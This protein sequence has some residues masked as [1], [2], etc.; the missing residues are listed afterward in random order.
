MGN[1]LPK[2]KTINCD[3]QCIISWLI[4]DDSI[5]NQVEDKKKKDTNIDWMIYN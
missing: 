4:C 1:Y 2:Q 3:D 5:K